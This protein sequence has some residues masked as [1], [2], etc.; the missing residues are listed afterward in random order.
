MP[1][2]QDQL[3][4]SGHYPVLNEQEVPRNITLKVFF[5]LEIQ[6]ESI[7][8]RVISL[9]DSMYA[10]VPGNVGIDFTN[11]GTPEARSNVLTFTP[12][13]TLLPNRQYTL[14]VHKAPNSVVSKISNDQLKETFRFSFRTG[15]EL[16]SDIP[17]SPLDQ[18]KLDLEQA[19]QQGNF[20]LAAQ[21]QELINQY[22]SGEIP[23]D[24]DDPDDP[25]IIK[26]LKLI[27]T[28]PTNEQANVIGL[29]YIKLE[30][31]DAV[32]S[33]GIA[34]GRYIQVDPKPVLE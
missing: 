14:Y 15:T 34:L 27:N 1:V 24:P 30:F 29:N 9:H 19:I 2:K 22:E 12:T 21:I 32:Q 16:L 5:N 31:N 7:N 25:V 33:S 26:D 3:Y 28:Y 8:Y 4:V 17:L 13:I 20:E 23:S 11:K 6:P 10:S 18:L